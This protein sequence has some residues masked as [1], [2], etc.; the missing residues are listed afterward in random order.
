[1]LSNMLEV[2][3]KLSSPV[4]LEEFLTGKGRSVDAEVDQILSN[5]AL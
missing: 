5:K 4:C 3:K 1:M 2:L